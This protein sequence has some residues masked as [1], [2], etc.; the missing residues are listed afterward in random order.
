MQSYYHYIVLYDDLD[1]TLENFTELVQDELLDGNFGAHPSL[2]AVWFRPVKYLGKE[3]AF[4]VRV[5]GPD[6]VIKLVRAN[7]RAEYGRLAPP[8]EDF[9]DDG[10]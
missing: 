5:R 6:K 1:P 7:L 10:K 8:I 3:R 4:K 2:R 9:P